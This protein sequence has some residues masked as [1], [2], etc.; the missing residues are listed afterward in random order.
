MYN[1]DNVFVVL[2]IL[3]SQ[4]NSLC[5]ECCYSRVIIIHRELV[6]SVGKVVMDQDLYPLQ[7]EMKPIMLQVR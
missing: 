3:L 7:A 1:S 6:F 5:Y 2:L 4:F